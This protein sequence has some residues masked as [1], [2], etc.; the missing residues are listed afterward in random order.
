MS[1]F[2]QDPQW[3]IEIERKQNSLFPAEQAIKV[4]CYTSQLK[5]RKKC[6]EIVCLTP[7]GSQIC[8]GFKEHDLIRCESK[9]KVVVS[10]GS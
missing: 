9:V 10:L 7:A 3:N 5:N 6:E 1:L 4:F 8:G 2:P